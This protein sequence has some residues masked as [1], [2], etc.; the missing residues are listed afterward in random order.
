MATENQILE[1]R[2]NIEGNRKS[3]GHSYDEDY[4]TVIPAGDYVVVTR[5]GDSDTPS[6]TKVTVKAGERTEVSVP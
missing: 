1:A 5:R 2:K 3:I 6:E 4:Q